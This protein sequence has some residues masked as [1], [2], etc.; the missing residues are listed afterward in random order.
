MFRPALEKWGFK[1]K[2]MTY[3]VAS[4]RARR[5]D[6]K[7]PRAPQL[8]L[9]I[10]VM[11]SASGR[12][13]SKYTDRARLLGRAIAEHRCIVVTGACPGLPLA[14]AHGAHDAGA[15]VVGISPGLSLDEHLRKYRSPVAH[16]DVL[17]FTGSGLMGREVVNIRSS[18]MVAILGGRSGTL[19]ELAIAYDEGKL[20][21]VLRGMGG[22][23]DM[24]GE[25]LAVC[26]KNTGAHVLY[27]H[28]PR[29]LIS[30]MMTAYCREHYRRPSVFET[31]REARR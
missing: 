19:G 5:Q 16:H 30:R 21:G 3:A 12:I 9:K 11:G 17:I 13:S 6:E 14:A 18:D 31:M 29:R 7:N 25:I 28:D 23:S 22:I 20:I 8:T 10:G 27:D 1:M 26:R 2:T 24:V 15:L 4:R